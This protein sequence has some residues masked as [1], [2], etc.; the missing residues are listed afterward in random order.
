MNGTP[1]STP[2]HL[3]V[4]QAWQGAVA[5]CPERRSLWTEDLVLTYGELDR[6]SRHIAARLSDAGVGPGRP[7]VT[8]LEN[9]AR[10]V[11]LMLA[12]SRLGA[13]WVPLDPEQTDSEL[14]GLVARSGAAHALVP[15][16]R[17]AALA[18]AVPGVR[19][20]SL[21]D[22]TAP[23]VDG[24]PDPG[25]PTVEI[26]PGDPW[27]IVYTSGSTAQPR[28]VVIP[29]RTFA[30]TGRALADAAGFT[31]DDVVL[32]VLPMHHLSVSVMSFGPA[33]TN[34]CPMALGGKFSRSGFFDLVRASGSTVTTT[35]P[36]VV[37]MLL[38]RE[39]E[40][41]DRDHPLRLVATHRRI[42]AFTERF[43]TRVTALWGMSE[44]G[45]LGCVQ[46]P[47]DDRP[48]T[49]GTP[50][51]PDAEVRLVDPL[52][53]PV[54]RGQVGE[55]WFRHPGAMLGN[56]GEE[57]SFDGWV[58]SGDLFSQ[59]ED[60]SYRYCGRSKNMIKR[61]GEN[62]ALEEIERVLFEHPAVEEIVVVPVPDPVYVEEACAVVVWRGGE[63]RVEELRAFCR[64]RLVSW[65]EP[66]YILGWS[67]YLPELANHKIDR[68]A[69]RR[70]VRLDEADDK[71]SGR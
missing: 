24:E 14:H 34:G 68:R 43:G 18:A 8:A 42:D 9:S 11:A 64:E 57:A 5:R 39:P 41:T 33:V 65:K 55:L 30:I 31:E 32:S 6:W 25:L 2:A 58:R 13:V 28:G 17:G 48:D 7:V 19:C 56:Q 4:A 61:G 16:A 15:P 51:P 67:D 37:E 1:I 70:G 66:R 44:T 60:G 20:L 45:G 49:V 47:G 54:E 27:A 52:G 50:Y 29:Q 40:P 69:V 46:R 36:T 10:H 23:P 38:T 53:E 12:V 22:V 63:P 21:D 59:L 26:D 3:T 71:Q 35:V 62:I